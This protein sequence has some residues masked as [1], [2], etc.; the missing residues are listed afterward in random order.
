MKTSLIALLLVLSFT[1]NAQKVKTLSNE[2]LCPK[3]TPSYALPISPVDEFKDSLELSISINKVTEGREELSVNLS[4]NETI[5]NESSIVKLSK[6]VAMRISVGRVV[7]NGEKFY[8]Y[9]IHLY[10]KEKG[11]W[12]DVYPNTA[13]NMFS[14]GTVTGGQG[15]GNQGT[16][17]FVSFNGNVS[18]L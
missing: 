15:Y 18:V 7:E 3:I 6:N 5:S 13:W 9:A 4:F 17:G 16:S 12:E 11:C 1:S 2:D 10:R 8:I 14:L